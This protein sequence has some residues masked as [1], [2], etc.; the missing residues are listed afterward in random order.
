MVCGP[1]PKSL[2]T[3]GPCSS[4]KI[5]SLVWRCA[6]SQQSYLVKT[7]AQGPRRTAPWPPGEP[8]APVEKPCPRLKPRAICLFSSA[9]RCERYLRRYYISPVLVDTTNKY[10]NQESYYNT[11][12]E[13]T[14]GRNHEGGLNEHCG[15]DGNPTRSD[16]IS[17]PSADENAH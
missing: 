11:V 16:V 4:I 15:A 14:D 7:S 9:S 13:F 10:L 8:R 12:P 17:L 5:F 3:C 6:I 2:N 1:L